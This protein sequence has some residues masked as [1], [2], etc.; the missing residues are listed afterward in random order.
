[1][2][3]ALYEREFPSKHHDGANQFAGVSIDYQPG[4]SLTIHQQPHI[5]MAYDKFIVDKV[6]ASRSAAVSRPAISDRDS[7]YHYSK[8]GLA[9]DDTERARM[10]S[11][12]FLQRSCI[13]FTSRT[14]TS[15]STPR[16]SDS[17]CMT[18]QLHA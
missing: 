10:K 1:M 8:L 2:A 14:H 18:L 17:L 16:F 9:Q 7:P 12:P 6:A 15:A 13:S 5:E 4:V 3:R 11:L